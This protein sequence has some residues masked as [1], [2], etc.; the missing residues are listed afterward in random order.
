MSFEPVDFIEIDEDE[1]INIIQNKIKENLSIDISFENNKEPIKKIDADTYWILKE[2]QYKRYSHFKECLNYM[3]NNS[4]NII[5]DYIYNKILNKVND[6]NLNPRTIKC[7]Q[8]K[9]I[10]KELQLHQYY[11]YIPNIIS[12]LNGIP[13][14]TISQDIKEKMQLMFKQIQEPYNKFK[15]ANQCCFLPYP[16]VLHKFWE[17]L[18]QK[19]LLD[20]YPLHLSFI[21]IY[22]CDKIWENICIELGWTF[23]STIKKNE[24]KYI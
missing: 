16:Y 4:K 14:P 22:R 8:I 12:K 23:I 19:E 11:E 17:L 13:I 20:Y 15:P 18:E 2:C 21:G 7:S 3:D 10:L 9:K 6:I 5:P 24:L 1:N